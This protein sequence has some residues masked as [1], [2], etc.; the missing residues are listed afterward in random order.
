VLASGNKKREAV[1]HRHSLC[2]GL[3]IAAGLLLSGCAD[4][5]PDNIG[6]YFSCS[7]W[8]LA[9]QGTVRRRTADQASAKPEVLNNWAIERALD[10]GYEV[11]DAPVAGKVVTEAVLI[12]EITAQCNSDRVVLTLGGAIT[13]VLDKL[14]AQNASAPRQP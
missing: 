2:A 11:T 14:D 4:G 6:S 13:N 7:D 3:F 10:R 12:R 9:H 1:I 5:D 8:M